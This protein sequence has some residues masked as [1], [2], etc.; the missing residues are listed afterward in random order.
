VGVVRRVHQR[1][2]PRTA[3]TYFTL[4]NLI[5]RERVH[6]REILITCRQKA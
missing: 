4:A 1:T 3:E 6:V 5:I 2:S